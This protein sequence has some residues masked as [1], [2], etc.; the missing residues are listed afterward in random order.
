MDTQSVTTEATEENPLLEGLAVRRRPEPSV[1]TVFGASGD[2]THRKIIPALYSLALRGL[3]PEQ[4]AVL[5]VARTEQTTEDFV[6]GL[7]ASVREF[8]RDE[9]RQDVWDELARRTRYV[10]TDFANEEGQDRVARCLTELDEEY[11]TRGNR[12]YYF[13]VPPMAMAKLIEELGERRATTG[14]SMYA[15]PIVFAA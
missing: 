3:L 5:G 6:V 13:A 10:A 1:L 8:G 4:F 11:G 9:F 15:K 7:E 14:W 12:V 2:L